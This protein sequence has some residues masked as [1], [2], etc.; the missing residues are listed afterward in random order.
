M[1]SCRWHSPQARA[2]LLGAIARCTLEREKI[3]VLRAIKELEFDRAMGKVAAEDFAEISGRLRQRA[4]RLMRQ[5]DDVQA[6]AR[7]RV[8]RELSARVH[9]GATAP[10]PAVAPS[11]PSCDTVND[12][13]ARFCKGCGASLSQ[14]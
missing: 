5:L 14:G 3:I 12:A 11:C 1:N 10:E 9:G 4:L 13:D 2:G 7:A 6:E 8:E